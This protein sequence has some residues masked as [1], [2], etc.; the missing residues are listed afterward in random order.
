MDK[1]LEFDAIL[2]KII[3]KT[4]PDGDTHVYYDPPM[5]LK[6]KYPAIRYKRK[7]IDKL[8]ANNKAYGLRIPYEVTLIYNNPD[9]NYVLDL[10]DLP[11]SSHDRSYT[12]DNLY[13]DVLTIYY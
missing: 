12:A 8:Y 9:S 10:L 5:D 2:C 4:E 11:Y 7:P 1:R 13:H 6:M 3:N